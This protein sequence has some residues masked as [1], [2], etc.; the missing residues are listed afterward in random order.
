MT[1]IRRMSLNIRT[2][3]AGTRTFLEAKK[4]INLY[5]RKLTNNTAAATAMY[6]RTVIKISKLVHYLKFI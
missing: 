5:M 1:A 6:M 4:R 3:V 2:A